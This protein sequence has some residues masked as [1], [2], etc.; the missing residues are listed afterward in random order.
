MNFDP[1][2][3]EL[4][5]ETGVIIESEAFARDVLRLVEALMDR[6]AWKLSL[7]ADGELQWSGE[8]GTP[9]LR[10]EPRTTFWKRMRLNLLSVLVPES[11]L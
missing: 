1:R 7:A 6:G 11:V 2:S 9:P 5:T 10:I 8:P 3:A 4:N